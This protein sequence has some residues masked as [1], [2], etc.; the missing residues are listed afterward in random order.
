M[1]GIILCNALRFASTRGLSKRWCPL[2]FEE[3]LYQ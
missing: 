2:V 3:Q 1:Q